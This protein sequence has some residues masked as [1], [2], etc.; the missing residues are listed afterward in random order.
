MSADG[1]PP[2][3]SAEKHLDNSKQNRLKPFKVLLKV[4]RRT[5]RE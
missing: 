4:K 5:A 2:E 1:P 3:R